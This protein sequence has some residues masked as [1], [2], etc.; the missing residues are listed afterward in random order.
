MKPSLKDKIMEDF[1]NNKIQILVSTTVIEVGVN[2]P[3]ASI[4]VVE[5]AERFGLAQ[6]HQ[7]RGR[8]GRGEYKSY[9]VLKYKGKGQN[10]KERM[11]IMCETNDGF[12]IS[13]KDLE[14]RGSGDFFG[15][16]QHGIPDFK[17]AN[18]FTDM[19]ILKLAQ[20]AATKIVSQDPKLEKEEN[21]LLK[22]SVKDKFTDRIEI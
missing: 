18:L 7:L 15:T 9:C 1:K 13:Q 4:M 16:M 21:R 5:N 11:K 6:L 20:E 8:V 3:N 19:D 17:I 22:L 2:V 14:L 10:T 12:L